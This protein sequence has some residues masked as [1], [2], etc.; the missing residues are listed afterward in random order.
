MNNKLT[1]IAEAGVNHNGSFVRAIK[2][3]DK[4]ANTGADYVKFQ[5]YS[6]EE[7]ALKT[8]IKADYQKK[9]TNKKETQYEMLKKYELTF[10]QIKKLKQHCYDKKINFLASPFSLNKAKDLL[11]IGCKEFKIASGEITNYQLLDFL[12][13]NAKTIFLST[14]ASTYTEI[15]DAYKIIIKNNFNKK[16]LYI[17]HCSSSYPTKIYE[18]NT[19][20][21]TFLKKNFSCKVG[22]SDHTISFEAA[23][24]AVS[25]GAVVIEKHFTLNKKLLGPD[26]SSSLT[27]S[28]LDKYIKILKNVKKSLGIK[29]KILSKEEYKNRKYIRKYIVAKEDILKN[30]LFSIN[31]IDIKRC[32]RGVPASKFYR[33]INK[34]AKKFYKKDDII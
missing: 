19:S 24:S 8:L 13:R 17:L 4:A 23:C 33:F 6:T 3:I 28:E 1:F 20:T 34:K 29:K 15:R 5:Y 2:M 10:E 25:F 18:A 16:N 21:I 11:S 14:G 27:V 9:N 7:L 32:G 31:N 12:S 26:H 22:F 30:D